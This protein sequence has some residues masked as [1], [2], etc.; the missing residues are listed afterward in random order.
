MSWPR[1]PL[2]S[3]GDPGPARLNFRQGSFWYRAIPTMKEERLRDLMTAFENTLSQHSVFRG[4]FG[5]I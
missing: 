2:S 1:S 4:I 5:A 3:V